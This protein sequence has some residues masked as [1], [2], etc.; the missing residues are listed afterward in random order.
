MAGTLN[1]TLDQPGLASETVL[2]AKDAF[3]TGL[4]IA[5][6]VGALSLLALGIIAWLWLP[7]KLP[8]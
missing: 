7:K 3:L 2:Q 8:E 5:A 4:H 1:E 6:G